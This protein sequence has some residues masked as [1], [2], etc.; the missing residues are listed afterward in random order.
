VISMVFIN[1]RI[2]SGYYW[3]CVKVS[4]GMVSFSRLCMIAR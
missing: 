3:L 1:L 4:H 2:A